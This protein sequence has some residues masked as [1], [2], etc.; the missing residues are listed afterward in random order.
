MTKVLLA[1]SALGTVLSLT[2]LPGGSNKIHDRSPY[3]NVGTIV[4][5][6]WVKLPAGLWVL[7]FDGS[8]DYVDCGNGAS[9]NITDAITIE[10]WFNPA[11]TSQGGFM[12]RR[13]QGTDNIWQVLWTSQKIKAALWFSDASY[14][15]PIN[16]T[17]LNTDAW[18]HGAVTY[19]RADARVYVNG[20]LDMTP[21]SETKA[22]AT[23]SSPLWIGRWFA[24]GNP[25]YYFQGRIGLPRVYNRALSAL[26]IQNHFNQ[27][28]YLFGAW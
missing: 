9:L 12:V 7:S 15:N 22:L 26:A 16:D 14:I 18:Y 19:D 23:G 21:I 5:A 28:K 1:P 27:E 17:T 24:S 3:G 20:E 4:G 2:G 13:E 8:D 10:F 25:D 6:T 11:E